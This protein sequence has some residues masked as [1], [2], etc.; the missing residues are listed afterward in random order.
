MNSALMLTRMD[1]LMRAWAVGAI[2]TPDGRVATPQTEEEEAFYRLERRV[3]P[4]AARRM[5]E[6]PPRG[7]APIIEPGEAYPPDNAWGQ[8]SALL[9]DQLLR[10]GYK[11][12]A[13]DVVRAA[14][15][16]LPT[17]WDEYAAACAAEGPRQGEIVRREAVEAMWSVQ[18]AQYGAVAKPVP[19]AAVV[20]REPGGD[21]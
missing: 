15:W 2:T 5:L 14:G 20:E 18:R 13:A 4:W 16:A 12:E 9:Q 21:G 7:G 8:I 6:R 3:Q 10:A 17:D 11:A 19:Q 1:D